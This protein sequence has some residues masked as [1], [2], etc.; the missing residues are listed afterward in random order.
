MRRARIE[1]LL[2]FVAGG[3]A[4]AAE[5]WECAEVPRQPLGRQMVCRAGRL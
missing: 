1:L 3:L 2:H 5:G 4:D